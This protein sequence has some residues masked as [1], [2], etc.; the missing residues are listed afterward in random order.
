[1]M[2]GIAGL[3]SRTLTSWDWLG[4]GQ[5]DRLVGYTLGLIIVPDIRNGMVWI[6][7]GG[8]ERMD[9]GSRCALC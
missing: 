4:E 2:I 1:M 5:A 6:T 9:M 3:A 8:T 7:E